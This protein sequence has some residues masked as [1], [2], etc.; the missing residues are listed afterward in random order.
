MTDLPDRPTALA[1]RI[2]PPLLCLPLLA[3]LVAGSGLQAQEPLRVLQARPDDEAS[4]TDE[5]TVIFDRPVAG[6][7]DRTVSAADLFSIEPPVEGRARWRDP[8]TLQF[9][10]EG[11]LR[12][13]TAYRVT[14]SNDFRAVDGS[15]LSRP[16]SFRFRTRGPRLLTGSPVRGGRSALHL[17]TDPTFELVYGAPVDLER[18]G[19]LV[20]LRLDDEC[21]GSSRVALLP[22]GQRPVSPEDPSH[23]RSRPYHGRGRDTPDTLARVVTL[24]L[25][26]ELPR[27]CSGDLVA[28]TRVDEWGSQGFVQWSFATYGDLRVERVE[29]RRGRPCPTGPLLVGFSNPVRGVE[30]RDHVHFRPDVDFSVRDTAR[31]SRFWQLEGEFEPRTGYRLEI[32]PGL[33]DVF[34]QRLTGQGSFRFETSGY[35][36]RVSYPYGRQIVERRGLRTLPVR[37]MNVD[38][39]VV[40]TAPVPDSLEPAFLDRRTWRWKPLWEQVERWARDRAIPVESDPDRRYVTGIEVPVPDA[41][42]PD[43]PTLRVLQVGRPAPDSEP[44]SARTWESALAVVQVTNLAVHAR[45]GVEEGIVWVT[46]LDDG[47]P[48]AGVRVTLHSEGGEAVARART[49]DRGLAHLTGFRQDTASGDDTRRRYSGFEGYVSARLGPDRALVGISR[50]EPDLSPWDLGAY[51]GWGVQRRPMAGAVFTGRGIYRPGET[52]HAKAV[53][54]VGKLG[55]LR[56]PTSGDSLRWVFSDRDGE[57]LRDTV[58]V[59]SRHGSSDQRLDLPPS[60][61]L[62]RYR[63]GVHLRRDGEWRRI[64]WASYRVAEYRPPE[65][66]VRAALRDTAPRFPGDT[67]RAEV[68]ARYLFGAPMARADVEWVARLDPV[69]WVRIPDAEGFRFGESGRWWEAGDSRSSGPR[70]VARGRDSLDAGGGISLPVAATTPPNGRPGRVRLQATVTDVNDQTGSAS[71]SVTIHPAAFYLGARPE[72]ESYFWEGGEE[73]EVSVIAARPD[74][75]RVEGVTVDGVVIRREW[76]RVRRVREG[77]PEVVGEWVADTAATCRL[78]T[79]AEPRPCR[80]TPSA[81]GSYVVR[82]S[83]TDPVGRPVATS[84]RRWAVGD[85]WVPWNDESQ[86]AMEVIPDRERYSVGDTATVLFASPFTDA[87]AWVTVEREGMI[88]QR[89]IR[90]E[91][92][93][94]TLEF[95]VTEVYVPNAFVSIL[96]TR[97][98]SAPPGSLDDPGRP[99]MRVGYAE[100]R[101]TPEV[102]RLSVDV[103][104]EREEYRPGDS[105]SVELHVRDA[106]GQGAKS[107]VTLW[108]VDEGILA[109]TGYETPDLLDLLYRPRGLGLR[110]GSNLL[111]VAA[112][113]TDRN[114]MPEEQKGG[115]SPGGGGGSEHADILRSRFQST[116]F[117]LGSV[118]TAPDGRATARARLPDNLT[119]FR[120]MAVAVT[121]EDRYGSG[122]SDLLV[123][124]PLVARPALPRFVRREDRFQ[125]GVVVNR[126]DGGSPRV[127][128]SV[129]AEGID[130]RG[131]PRREIRL[132]PGRGSEVRFEFEGASADTATLR[133]TARSGGDADAVEHRLPVEPSH[134]PRAHTVAGLVR[135]ST[136]IRLPLPAGIDPER[137]TLEMSFGSSPLA[138]IRGAY[139]RLRVYPYRGTEPVAS[140][141]RALA[142]LLRAGERT[143]GAEDLVD[144]DVALREIEQAVAVITRRQGEDGSIGYWSSRDWSTPWLTSYAGTVLLE[145]READ[146]AVDD[147]VL[148][149][150]ADYLRDYLHDP[151]PLPGPVAKWQE[152][153]AVR[154]GERVAATDFL[155]RLG[156]PDLPAEHSLLEQVGV[157]RWEDRVRLAE[158]LARRGARPPAQAILEKAWQRVRVEGGRAILPDWAH[159][160]F[161]FRS[162]VRPAAWL[163]RA[164]LS[165]EP[166]HPGVGPLV[167]TVL[168]QGRVRG[169]RPW[170]T[171]D[172]G[173]AVPALVAYDRT[174]AEA[175]ARGVELRHAGRTLFQ[176][177]TDSARLVERPLAG[178]LATGEDGAPLL[179]LSLRARE[180]GPPAYY[181]VTV[182]EI[183]TS[184]PVRPDMAGIQ[185]ERWYE[186]YESGEPTTWV[187]EGDLV[188]VNLRMTVRDELYFVVLDDPLPAGLE[189]VDLSLRTVGSPPPLPEGR[190]GPSDVGSRYRY[191]RTDAGWWSPFDHREKRDERVVYSATVLW[192]GTYSATYLARATTPG[193][194]VKP[195]A[196]AEEMY[197]PAVQGR[198]EGGYFQVRARE[199]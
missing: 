62:G 80:F 189:A 165:V 180:P 154:L 43:A 142:A 136:R 26:R 99:T 152:K 100:L 168:L 132:D 190:E 187:D 61:P 75:Q 63:V 155:S 10:P 147:A 46:G 74:G 137:S 67:V 45:I 47:E 35:G 33:E 49:D 107:E 15:R 199:P 19:R 66:L 175:V 179:E 29:C 27:A 72:G 128:V 160:G 94:T 93:T 178:L 101:V 110:L 38:S 185:V 141:A 59:L 182:R 55:A 192:P 194:F 20:S 98:R 159:G 51:S 69:W 121:R 193:L 64:G 109:L 150:I 24:E 140:T 39:L 123:T 54:R 170:T 177:A 119:T 11:V 2:S 116:A 85:G 124:R 21:P 86:F 186:R 173:A 50:W 32:A 162:R 195:P 18:L 111:A 105:A 81:G 172:F 91:S 34:G 171:Q 97:G 13:A 106:D 198:S 90:V 6:S 122:E 92:G 127:S 176:A 77:V 113:V 37:H 87:E 30:V 83:A 148:E 158:V 41:R 169:R 139:R 183:P 191:G 23:Y 120:V 84:V 143:G 153:M 71:T 156:Q 48:R 5:V 28:P 102:K 197:N 118:E 114:S 1:T 135:D 184:P 161:Y 73:Q 42:E 130:L 31:E 144:R 16:Y 131:E 78:V 149:R 7:L 25:G 17:P 133:F 12:P 22:T 115:R 82:L 89:R 126:R 52:V 57:A 146:V 9:V 103:R 138:V 40:R 174:Q 166:E 58:V 70:I 3:S 8:A 181:Y 44:D 60:A 95:P 125:A 76:H 65:F 145:A 129:E 88:E 104:P 167:E 4:M 79:A 196:H 108:A 157:M 151:E 163:L 96:L 68:E 53:A 117:F 164:L 14:V 134:H 36:P 188:R 112:Q 56:V